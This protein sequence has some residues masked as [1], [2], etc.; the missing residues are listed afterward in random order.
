M[1]ATRLA[2][3]RPGTLGARAVV[4]GG[5]A[6]ELIAST[7]MVADLTGR[8]RF[9]E[10]GL[11][12][13]HARAMGA[14]DLRTFEGLGEHGVMNLLGLASESPDD[15]NAADFLAFMDSL[16]PV[17]IVLNAIGRYRRTILRS[18]PGEVIDDAVAGDP[19]ARKRFLTTSWA[20]VP[21]WQTTLRFLF[22]RS[23]DEVGAAIVRAF[24]RWHDRVFVHEAARLAEAQQREVA[25]LRAEAEVWRVDTL[26][27]RIAPALEY[28]PPAG[29]EL[30]TVV[31]ITSIR[32]AIL[33][34]DHRM[35]SIVLS[36][37]P[38][39]PAADAPPERLVMLGKAL[40]DELR[41][42]TLRALASGPR[43]LADLATELGVPRTS[44]AHH[45]A[46]LRAAGFI[47]HTIDDGRWGR[48]TLRPDAVTNVE[49]LLRG[50]LLK[51]GGTRS[52]SESST[53]P[54]R[55]G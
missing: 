28:V 48:L 27:R 14:T 31:P 54:R 49:P 47:T 33:F 50:F 26:L 3:P 45:I 20:D 12:R 44:L 25:A 52:P 11:W 22:E 53:S 9:N 2:P 39:A 36:T 19:A 15:R 30:V 34:L 13:R 18:A 1:V 37:T 16:L 41:L 8:H 10:V 35:E 38:D 42:R 43:S 23:P 55:R 5:S 29:V 46:I 40:G 6:F 4:A 7:L 32:P 24:Q 17:E 21:A 51:S